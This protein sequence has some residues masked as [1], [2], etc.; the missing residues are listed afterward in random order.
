MNHTVI[1]N[2][3]GETW[4][5]V[6]RQFLKEYKKGIPS[7]SAT[8]LRDSAAMLK[9]EFPMAKKSDP[10][11]DIVWFDDD[12]TI[13]EA[14]KAGLKMNGHGENAPAYDDATLVTHSHAGV[15]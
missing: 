15:R 2:S 6:T 9:I 13:E 1:F 5:W 4:D 14:I 3:K 8:M 7:E 11:A 12:M 10:T